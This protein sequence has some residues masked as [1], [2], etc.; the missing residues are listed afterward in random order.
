MKVNFTIR[1]R[2][3]ANKLAAKKFS[4]MSKGFTLI[5]LLISMV[6]TLVIVGLLL[7]M[8]K[9]AVGAWTNTSKKAKSSRLA[10][11]VFD[12]AGRDLEGMLVRNGN[13]H[14]WVAVKASG[15]SPGDLGP[16]PDKEI[17]NAL[18]VLFFTATP[19]RYDGQINVNGGDVS[20]VRY[21]LVYQDVI[22]PG[23]GTRPVYSLYR[24]R[25]E[26]DLTFSN[27]L[28]VDDIVAV[29]SG[30]SIT[31]EENILAENIYDF[32]LSYTFEYTITDD[33]GISTKAYKRV[34]MQAE[35]DNQSLS[36]KGNEVLVNGVEL[37]LPTDANEE[38]SG[39]RLYSAN[40]SLC[41]L[42]D[43]A[44]RALQRAPGSIGDFDDFVKKNGD[45]YTKSVILPRP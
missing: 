15:L 8:T 14:E 25:I 17:T 44:I 36:I 13:S 40:L 29:N 16:A 35:G 2:A 26:P 28:A 20:L 24:E 30:D 42:S 39:A 4:K 23:T 18:D 22:E 11:E 41:V 7:G 33:N 10:Q 9:V 5:E 19:D 1:R 45:V 37:I 31:E 12:T 27:Y 6:I 32:T 38:A 21:R 34:A 43:S 3:L